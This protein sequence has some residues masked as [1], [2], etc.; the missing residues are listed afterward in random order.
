M[1]STRSLIEIFLAERALRVSA[2]TVRGDEYYLKRFFEFVQKFGVDD[3]RAI[4]PEHLASFYFELKSS[5]SRRGKP[6]SESFVKRSVEVP[7]LFFV[8][9]RQAG[10][11]LLDFGAFPTQRVPRK[12]VTVPSVEQVER[13]LE[14][15]DLTTSDGL[16]DRLIFELFYTLGL[17]RQECHRLDIEHL[18]LGAG[19][20][21]VAGKGSRERLLPLSPRLVEFFKRY[22]REARPRL[23]PC[24]DE[25]ALW[26]AAQTGRR[27][28]YES[29]KLRVKVFCAELGLDITPHQLRHA[30]ATHLLEGGADIA[31][32]QEL[33][34]H[35][36]TSS[37]EIYT[38]VRP[39]EL[40][41]EHQR[42]HPRAS[43]QT[44]PPPD[45]QT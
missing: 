42:C 14:A 22:L 2:R 7:K 29:L 10:F 43:F 34:G 39:L 40:H 27:L 28:G 6:L 36:R 33:L 25:P 32:I 31:Y 16:R 13:L 20:V 4:C 8:W 19:T 35:Q 30:C 5:L 15:P 9:A 12:L 26:I 1:P 44:E 23:R 38:R 21:L 37:T 17:R 41:S 24:P 3:V 18:D 45:E 11:V